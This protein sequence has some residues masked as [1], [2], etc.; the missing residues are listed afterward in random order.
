VLSCFEGCAA[1]A[2][3]AENFAGEAVLPPVLP[4]EAAV[5]RVPG[6]LAGP[7]AALPDCVAM[8]GGGALL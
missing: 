3:D 7:T 2:G 5:D 1:G 8:T 4:M 6:L